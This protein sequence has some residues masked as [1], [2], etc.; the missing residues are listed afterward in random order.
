MAPD[1]V[2]TE[3]TK[4]MPV[5][6]FRT[7]DD[8]TSPQQVTAL[9]AGTFT[10]RYVRAGTNSEASS[11][12]SSS[13]L[14]P[15]QGFEFRGRGWFLAAGYSNYL[16]FRGSCYEPLDPR[17]AVRTIWTAVAP[18]SMLTRTRRQCRISPK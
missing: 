13:D 4:S 15:E 8:W 6:D 16:S 12:L 2:E 11:M 1:V 3:T 5:H 18:G 9:A 10:E 14:I 7:G 17:V